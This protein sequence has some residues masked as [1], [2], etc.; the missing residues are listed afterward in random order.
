MPY[1]PYVE[2]VVEF[3][4]RENSPLSPLEARETFQD[5]SGPY[6]DSDPW[7][8]ERSRLFFD[9][10][11]F[12]HPSPPMRNILHRY[13]LEN[14]EKIKRD[15]LV[16]LYRG[17]MASHAG[18]FHLLKIDRSS[19][20]MKDLIGKVCYKVALPEGAYSFNEGVIINARVIPLRGA[21][22]LG[23]G[24]LLHPDEASDSIV[25]LIEDLRKERILSWR[26][27]HLLARMK[28]QHDMSPSFKLSTIYSTRSFLVRR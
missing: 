16:D 8:E 25:R 27:C 5:L 4:S 20:T 9:Y 21:L 24:I 22:I 26:S 3:Y 17:L 28:L 13:F 6:K 18:V 23:Q 14:I 1:L 12:D 10:L 19:V 2:R 11:V 15:D 7:Y